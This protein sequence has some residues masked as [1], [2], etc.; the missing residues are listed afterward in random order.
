MIGTQK[1][2]GRALVM[3]EAKSCND[4][5]VQLSCAVQSPAQQCYPVGRTR[6]QELADS[7]KVVQSRYAMGAV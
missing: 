3:L 1:A 4:G 6:G 7:K 5:A 2:V